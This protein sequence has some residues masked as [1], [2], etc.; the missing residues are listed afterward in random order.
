MK[1]IK[2]KMTHEERVSAKRKKWQNKRKR[3]AR[4]ESAGSEGAIS[5]WT[6]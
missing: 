3:E 2:E 4:N 5:S 1:K 6:V